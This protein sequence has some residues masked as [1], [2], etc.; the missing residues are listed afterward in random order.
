LPLSAVG[1][2][3][4][5]P[6]FGAYDLGHENVRVPDQA[7]LFG[8]VVLV[9]DRVAALAQGIGEARFI[10]RAVFAAVFRDIGHDRDVAPQIVEG[11][12]I[13][14]IHR[15]A[16]PK[17]LDVNKLLEQVH[18][19]DAFHGILDPLNQLGMV[20]EGFVGDGPQ[21]HRVGIPADFGPDCFLAVLEHGQRV[22][23]VIVRKLVRAGQG[24]LV[25]GG[26]CGRVLAKV[27]AHVFPAA[28]R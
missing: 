1:V 14:R 24:D 5:V 27:G 21:N 2:Q 16:D 19:D 7:K 13:I 3:N 17:V 12:V 11:A 10:R 9:H 6:G 18:G 23:V 28:S 4:Q 26:K 25:A 20:F 22:G 8:F 15:P